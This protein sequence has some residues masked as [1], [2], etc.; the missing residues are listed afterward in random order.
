[1]IFLIPTSQYPFRYFLIQVKT[2]K[3]KGPKLSQHV[4]VASFK[5][6]VQKYFGDFG[7]A[8]IGNLCLKYFNEKNKML[9]VRVSKGPH[10]LLASVIPIVTKV[11]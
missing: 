4:I 10:R 11:I 6:H 3:N 5:K 8:S 7:A 9:V 2:E 1:M